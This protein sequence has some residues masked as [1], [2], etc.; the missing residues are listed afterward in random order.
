MAR[1]ILGALALLSVMTACGGDDVSQD[2]QALEAAGIPPEPDQATAD[3]FIA[4]LDAINPAIVHRGQDEAGDIEQA[5]DRGRDQCSTIQA[6]PDDRALQVETTRQRFTSPVAPDG[7]P[8]EIAEQILDAV[9]THLCPG[10]EG[11]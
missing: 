1:W 5:I 9:L 7:W 8:P 10:G 11:Q 4:A 6:N 3:A 2:E